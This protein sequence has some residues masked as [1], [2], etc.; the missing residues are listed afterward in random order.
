MVFANTLYCIFISI[1]MDFPFKLIFDDGTRNVPKT[2]FI[3][4]LVLLKQFFDST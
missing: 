2:I 1:G 3:G 4:N